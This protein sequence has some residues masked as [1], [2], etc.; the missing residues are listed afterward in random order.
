[1]TPDELE[2]LEHAVFETVVQALIDYRD[3]AADV[4]GK[5]V[6]EAKDIAED[7]MREAVE[8]MGVSAIQS[9]LHGKVDY[10]KAM[11]VFL[12][13]A[14]PVALFLDAKTEKDSPNVARVQMSQTSMRVQYVNS[15]TGEVGIGRGT[16]P[17]TVEDGEG[18][19]LQV[20]SVI[21]KYVYR[22]LNAHH[23]LR[24]IVAAC[25][26]NGR[27]QDRYNPTPEDTIWQVGP[28][29]PSLDEDFRARLNFDRLRSKADWRV[30][31]ISVGQLR[32]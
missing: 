20:V 16:L 1:M 29:A 24:R 15:K 13:Q 31:D 10:K 14:R 11:Y 25:I 19:T 4:F 23:E 28:D 32:A 9:R 26:P 18:R 2:L 3:V 12:P 7:V 22:K 5:E 30:R 8:T 17:A 6:D 27:L 21:A